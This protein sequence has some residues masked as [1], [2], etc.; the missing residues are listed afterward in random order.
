MNMDQCCSA[1]LRQ[2]FDQWVDE[3]FTETVAFGGTALIAVELLK[4]F[5]RPGG[6]QHILGHDR[7]ARVVEH[8]KYDCPVVELPYSVAAVT[9]LVARTHGEAASYHELASHLEPVT[10]TPVR[11]PEPHPPIG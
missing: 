11:P 7:A 2:A 8:I 6:C 5:R 3:G 1:E 4:S 10:L 9:V